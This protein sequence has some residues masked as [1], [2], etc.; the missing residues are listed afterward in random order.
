[1]GLGAKRQEGVGAV[2]DKH[3]GSSLGDFLKEEEIFE[4]AQAQAMKEVIA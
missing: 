4:E 1:L 2:R 3:L